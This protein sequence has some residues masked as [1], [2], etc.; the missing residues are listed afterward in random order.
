MR[1]LDINIGKI[2]DMILQEEEEVM[3]GSHASQT[4][5][6]VRTHGRVR[7]LTA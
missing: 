6:R 1:E 7:F 5:N 3:I 4:G 2:Q